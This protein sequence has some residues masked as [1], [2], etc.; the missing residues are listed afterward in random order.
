MKGKKV[1]IN[2][3]I[4]NK[5]MTQKNEK[6]ERRKELQRKMDDLSID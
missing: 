2:E 5:G 4:R 3:M 1:R 6:K